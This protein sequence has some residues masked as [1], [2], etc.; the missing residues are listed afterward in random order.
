M[1]ALHLDYECDCIR[2]DDR[3]RIVKFLSPTAPVN[4]RS[5]ANAF[6]IKNFTEKIFEDSERY[7]RNWVDTKGINMQSSDELK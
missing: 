6:F 5:A 3:Y 1:E 4:R 7:Y 2:K